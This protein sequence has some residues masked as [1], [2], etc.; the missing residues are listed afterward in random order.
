MRHDVTFQ[1]VRSWQRRGRI[2]D[3]L[4]VMIIIVVIIIINRVI[5]III[6]IIVV[7]LVVI[8]IVVVV[9]VAQHASAGLIQ[10]GCLILLGGP[11][12]GTHQ[13]QLF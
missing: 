5:T 12:W 4:V 7:V 11:S 10:A 8:V 9:V 2:V 6:T 3:K 13:Q 1:S